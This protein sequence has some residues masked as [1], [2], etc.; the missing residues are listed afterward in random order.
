VAHSPKNHNPI[1]IFIGG[2]GRSG[3]TIF[4]DMLNEHSLIRTS[5][6]T[7]IKF[8]ANRGGLLDVIFGSPTSKISDREGIS[9]L[10]YRTYR[11]RKK[12]SAQMRRDNIQIFRENLWQKW[13]QIDAKPPHGPGLHTGITKDVLTQLL[14]KFEKSINRTPVRAGSRFMKDFIANQSDSTD[15]DKYWVETTPMNISYARHLLALFPHAKFIV[16]RRDPRD[17]IASLVTKDWGPSTPLEGVEWIENR[18]RAGHLGQSFI[19]KAQLLT[20]DLEDLVTNSPGQTYNK[21][22]TFLEIEDE[23]A[24]RAFHEEKMSSDLASSGRWKNQIDSPEFSQAI[25]EMAQ[26]LKADGIECGRLAFS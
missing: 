26:R 5:N 8:L 1:P 13:W 9:I 22:L 19:P 4:G 7:E 20:I 25:T 3:T 16:M 21:I 12:K 24:M 17:V 11:N 10:H 23:P 18:L 14:N 6:P 2:T 15:T